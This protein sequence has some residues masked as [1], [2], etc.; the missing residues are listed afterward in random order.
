MVNQRQNN[1]SVRSLLWGLCGFFF[2]F[3][4]CVSAVPLEL[5]EV[6][7]QATGRVE[8]NLMILMDS[9]GSMNHILP[10]DET[11]DPN[12]SYASCYYPEPVGSTVVIL[13]ARATGK[14]WYS[15]GGD[16]RTWNS[17]NNCFSN[18]SQ[19]RARLYANTGNAE[20][21]W[22]SSYGT[23]EYTGHFLN[24]YFSRFSGGGYIADAF[25]D[26]TGNALRG[27]EGTERR[28]DVAQSAARLLVGGFNNLRVGLAQFNG[29]DGARI[30]AGLDSVS[31]DAVRADLLSEIDR[32]SADG[33]TPLAEALTDIGYY[34]IEGHTGRKV[35]LHPD[36]LATKVVAGNVL[37]A[38]KDPKTGSFPGPVYATGVS[39]PTTAKPAIQYYCQP[40]TV[41]ALTDGLPTRDS[42]YTTYLQNYD[43]DD[44]AANSDALDDVAQALF[45]VD[46]RP[47]LDDG[48]EE[49]KN[50]ISSYFIG[51]ADE[52]L[53]DN[54]LLQSAGAQG[55]GSYQFAGNASTLVTSLNNAVQAFSN[56]IGSQS[57]VSFNS[58]SLDLNSVIYSAQFDTLDFSGKLIAKPI[59][60]NTGAIG[61]TLWEASKKLTE[62][63]ASSREIIT[64]F[65]GV[66]VP[67][68]ATTSGVD[69]NPEDSPHEQDL[70][71][72]D[73][74][75]SADGLWAER[76]AYLR[77]DTSREG[78]GLRQRGSFSI[79]EDLLT[80]KKLLG[81]IVHSTPIYVGKPQSRWPASFGGDSAAQSYE[82]FRLDNQNRSAIVYVGAN[83]GMLHGFDADS[84]EEVFAYVPAL[85]LDATR[86]EG[87]HSYTHP[88]YRH[89]YYVDLTPAVSDIYID[90]D[91]S[92]IGKEWTSVLVG[93]LRGGGK[94][95][96]ALNVTDPSKLKKAEANAADIAL[97]EFNGAT[98]ANSL[99]YSYSDVQIARLNN[100]KWAAIFGNG[101]NSETGVAGLFIVYIEEGID[102]WSAGDWK[103]IS[104]GSGTD[105]TGRK[106]GLSSPW[107]IDL[108]KDRVVD[109][110]YAGDLMG[111]M[112]SFD[113]SAG[114]DKKWGVYGGKPLFS[115][116]DAAG[117][118]DRAI[119]ARPLV[120]RNTAVEG[121]G[122]NVLVL[123]GTGQYLNSG[124][125]RDNQPGSFYAVWDNGS[126]LGKDA[127]S[128]KAGDLAQQVLDT[129]GAGR[130]VIDEQ[131]SVTLDWGTH[132][133]WRMEFSTGNVDTN[134]YA[135]ERVIT[136]PKSRD[137]ILLFNTAIP[138]P[139]PCASSGT[140]FQMFIDLRTGR[141]NDEAVTDTNGDG[142]INEE[143]NGFVGQQ[144]TGCTGDNCDKDGDGEDD[145]EGGILGENKVIG[146]YVCASDSN[147]ND[148]CR[149]YRFSDADREGRLSWEEFSPR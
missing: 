140:S 126:T 53:K 90:A 41:I 31:V 95:Y 24:W 48:D 93:G 112:W 129:D 71:F 6:P 139:T 39:K 76:L 145:N 10:P 80:G 54:P 96:F 114:S 60:P 119:L 105:D 127:T 63:S 128:I 3:S 79:V 104:T 72:N 28:M 70:N 56:S 111:N 125:L 45:E 34:F 77:G 38:K 22:T 78:S 17:T 44:N 82:Q 144:Y 92:S 108:N 11:Y 40:S 134:G 122:A 26:S 49:A 9:S 65:N 15:A 5:S 33:S 12:A 131:T 66:G 74:T 132:H 143:D 88:D 36:G 68:A 124:D 102:G 117:R 106:N 14:V 69:G 47:D 13:I 103:F 51:F 123:F 101:Y 130:R 16:W 29:E 135:G 30:L 61:K 67:F 107:L 83:D 27:K 20:Y 149:K 57:S 35:E 136:P 52:S 23:A 115:A 46:W 148:N 73:S 7:L 138:N 1:F 98:D 109:R 146:E 19:Y 58:T 137:N 147:A 100:G 133:G 59:D 43:G 116:G 86:Y 121:E 120:V 2:A 141:S 97:W 91:D 85:V 99:G 84:G 50:N 62:K 118:P 113:L 37:G 18:N 75:N 25:K 64:Y 4:T 94:G 87:L 110:V 21:F 89:N 142:D 8:S 32:I 81:D 42:A 55:G